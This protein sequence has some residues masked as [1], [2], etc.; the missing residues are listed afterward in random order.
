MAFVRNISAPG[1]CQAKD[2]QVCVVNAGERNALWRKIMMNVLKMTSLALVLILPAAALAEED[3]TDEF[4]I[5][6]CKFR[7]TGGNNYFSLNVGYQLYLTNAACLA[8]GECDELEEVWISVLNETRKI[9]FELNGETIRVNAR[10]VEEREFEDG[11]IDEVS[12]NFFAVCKDTGDVYY[13][14]EDVD[15]YE[16][17]EIDNHEGAWLAGEN[18]ALPGLIMP[19]GA[20][21]LGAG[22]FQEIA[23]GVA[24]DRGRHVAMGLTVAVPAG[25]FE[26][27]VMIEDTDALEPEDDPDP[28][29]Y[30][31]GVGLVI[32]EELELTAIFGQF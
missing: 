8:E 12:R 6:D 3:F 29:V 10:V 19:G 16:D 21:L 1:C 9:K 15:N 5:A 28:K 27:C 25:Q 20:F 23:P 17:G 14:G 32:D 22:Y 26:N 11:E 18:G 30:C 2:F 31:P 24:L 13:F 7:A 4:P